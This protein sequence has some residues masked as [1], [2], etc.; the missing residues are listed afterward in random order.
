[1]KKV[2]MLML[3]SV[4][5]MPT[6]WAEERVI[7]TSPYITQMISALGVEDQLVG[8]DTTSRYNDYL[9]TLPDIGY[10]IALSTEGMLSLNP[11]LILW[12]SDS[13]PSNVV[14]QVNGSGVRSM[15]LHKPAMLDDLKASVTELGIVFNQMEKSIAINQSLDDKY[16]AIEKGIQ[17]RGAIKT[18]FIMEEMGSK[19][20]KSFAGSETSATALIELLG[21]HNPFADQFKSYKSVNLETQIQQGAEIVLIGQRKEYSEREKSIVRRDPSVIGWP[22]GFA[23]K[24]VFEVDI[25]HLLVYGIYLYDDAL[26]LNGMIGECLEGNPSGA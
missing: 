20:A 19:N 22:K 6:V 26:I 25:S 3:L 21:L 4:I 15:T 17:K 14:A 23:A 2:I 1:M 12:S 24:C 8:V 9:K 16:Q 5:H 7:T 13:G 10:R 18:L 11:T